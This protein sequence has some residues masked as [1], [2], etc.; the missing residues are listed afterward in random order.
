MNG[1]L[2]QGNDNLVTAELVEAIQRVSH[3][4]MR[5]SVIFRPVI[6]PDGDKFCCLLGKNLVDGIAAFGDTPD[7]ACRV[8][9]EAWYKK[10]G[11]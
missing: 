8:F 1:I 4:W 10:E 2:N 11:Q 9:D 5:P 3:E 7:Q 6:F